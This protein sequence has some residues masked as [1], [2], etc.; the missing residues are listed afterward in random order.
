MM[1][2]KNFA[3]NFKKLSLK[4]REGLLVKYSDYPLKKVIRLNVY[5]DENLQEH[6]KITVNE[7]DRKVSKHF[8]ELYHESFAAYSLFYVEK[9]SYEALMTKKPSF[10][11]KE[12]APDKAIKL[13]LDY[14][15]DARVFLNALENWVKKKL[16]EYAEEWE[17]V[18]KDFYST[19]IAYR[20]CYHLRNFVQH[21]MM[22]PINA[23]TI[24]S[25]KKV[26]YVL[27]ANELQKDHQF[28]NSVEVKNN[29]FENKENLMLKKYVYQY[30][31]Q[32]HIL[33]LLAM[34]KYFRAKSKEIKNFHDY[35]AKR[36]FPPKL[37]ELVTTKEQLLTQGTASV[38]QL[39]TH[40]TV[41][42]FI[43]KLIKWGF[44]DYKDLFNNKSV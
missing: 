10:P 11:I 30:H 34:I 36:N 38:L 21:R 42:G 4:K 44:I 2:Q 37:Y 31:Q 12:N 18:R 3:D 43:D 8:R 39:D 33:Y 13:I 27:N 20:I 6:S 9:T 17:K 15:S 1:K 29:F 35:F 16:P 7:E 41:S 14:I 23:V 32:I 26:D 5:L 19:S 40:D 28:M 22:I 24:Y 25:D